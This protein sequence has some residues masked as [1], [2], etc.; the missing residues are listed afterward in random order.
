MDA[1]SFTVLE[2]FKVQI[3]KHQFVSGVIRHY[4]NNNTSNKL[5]DRV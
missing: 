3:I 5:P 1:E 2:Y 4:Y